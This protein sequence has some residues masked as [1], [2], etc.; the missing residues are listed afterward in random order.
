MVDRSTADKLY[1]EVRI[2]CIIPTTQDH[3]DTG[4]VAVMAATWGRKC[5]RILFAYCPRDNR[6]VTRS[7]VIVTCMYRE[8]KAMLLD[9]IIY[10]L[11]T[12]YKL[13]LDEFDWILKAD[14]DTYIVM[15]NLRYLLSKMD[16]TRPGYMGYHL[17]VYLYQGY[18]SGGAGYI[19]SKEGFRQVMENGYSRG[20]CET[21]GEVEDYEIGKCLEVSGGKG[22]ILQNDLQYLISAEAI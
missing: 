1:H 10:A 20:L 11:K 16:S 3:M 2:L 7:D 8:T 17:K 22:N 14:D 9:K 15:E 12:V 19:L 4:H 13:Y 21:T 6:H 18:N 5:N